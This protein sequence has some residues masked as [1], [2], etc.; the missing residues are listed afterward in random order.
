MNKKVI[1]SICGVLLFFIISVV[2]FIAFSNNIS[3]IYLD[4]NPSIML[5]VNSNKEVVEIK[6]LNEDAKNVVSDEFIN[7]KMEY[8]FE[9]IRDD[10]VDNRYS[11]DEKAHIIIYSEGSI[12]ND[13]LESF[14]V[15]L[16][17]QKD[18]V[19]EII[20]ID[21]ISEEDRKIAN[22]FN[23]SVSKAAYINMIKKENEQISVDDLI[24]KSVGE[25]AQIK[26]NKIYC[27]DGYILEGRDCLKEISRVDAVKGEVCPNGYYEYNEECYNYNIALE[28][29]EYYCEGDAK[30]EGDK[31]VTTRIDKAQ[32]KEYKCTTGT[33]MSCKKALADHA[34]EFDDEC[35]TCVDESTL[36]LPTYACVFKKNGKC[37]H[38]PGK[39]YWEGKC[40][41][42]DVEYNGKC[43]EQKKY[44]WKCSDGKLVKTKDTYCPSIKY[45]APEPVYACEDMKDTLDG[46]KCIVKNEVPAPRKVGCKEGYILVENRICIDLNNKASKEI[47]YKC[48]G[49]NTKLI[50]DKCIIYER[51]DAKND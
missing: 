49:E 35:I 44:E 28:T 43:Y 40:I 42:G 36:E 29:D 47:G 37:Y 19:V 6:A 5:K 27:D 9:K 23:I 20:R 32:I 39:P 4:I 41:N 2:C 50:N 33:P 24:D 16:F 12:T 26:E 3:T 51:I 45:T 13:E 18:C 17:S 7:K 15:D 1:I 25:L 22:D 8:V 46:E 10:V 34:D 48:E 11:K 14:L 30:L 38:G 31:C 21:N